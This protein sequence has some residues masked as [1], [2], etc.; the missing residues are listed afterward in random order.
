MILGIPS[1]HRSINVAY[2]T[3]AS[4]LGTSVLLSC[5][6]CLRLLVGL[7][8]SPRSKIVKFSDRSSRQNDNS[9]YGLKKEVSHF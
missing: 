9:L 3:L 6:T 2:I 1:N 4:V 7:M 8:K 5:P